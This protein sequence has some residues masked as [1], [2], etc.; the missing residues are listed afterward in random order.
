VKLWL[1]TS[2]PHKVEEAARIL[3]PWQ[4]ESLVVGEVA[5]TGLTFEQNAR[6]KAEAGRGRAPRVIAEDSGLVVDGLGGAP[7]F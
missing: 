1:V 4:V 5:E 7:G 2:N 6:L 3:A